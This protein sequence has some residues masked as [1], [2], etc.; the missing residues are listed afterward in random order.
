MSRDWVKGDSFVLIG[1]M[2]WVPPTKPVE[3]KG[4]GRQCRLM[5]CMAAPDFKRVLLVVFKVLNRFE[6][7]ST[8]STPASVIN[9]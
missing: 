5:C 9:V 8:A 2:Q 4:L 3:R 7:H 1:S 6:R